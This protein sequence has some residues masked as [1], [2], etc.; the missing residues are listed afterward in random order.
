[1][2]HRRAV[3]KTSPYSFPR[4]EG[5]RKHVECVIRRKR[6]GGTFGRSS[7]GLGPFALAVFSASILF[8][9][10]KGI[11]DRVAS[12]QRPTGGAGRATCSMWGCP[13]RGCDVRVSRR[14][15]GRPALERRMRGL[16]ISIARF[17]EQR[18]PGDVD[19]AWAQS[20]AG[21]LEILLEC[22]PTVSRPNRGM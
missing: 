18:A 11:A 14:A 2:T 5:F 8:D 3:S 16:L 4:G 19:R 17:A 9:R 13:M 1:M 15:L 20:V 12:R 22:G 21:S 6:A 10:G 7:K